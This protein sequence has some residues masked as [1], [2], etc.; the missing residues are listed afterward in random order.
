MFF[1]SNIVVFSVAGLRFGTSK[2]LL[3]DTGSIVQT[4]WIDCELLHSTRRYDTHVHADSPTLGCEEAK[5]ADWLH[6]QFE[7]K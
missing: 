7:S 6:A 3:S 1:L 4:D 2:W 5:S